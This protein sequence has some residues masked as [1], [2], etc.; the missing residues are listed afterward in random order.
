M[1]KKTKKHE[2]VSSFFVR[3]LIPYYY[4]FFLGFNNHFFN[5]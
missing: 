5:T 3:K 4:G 1:K 2:G